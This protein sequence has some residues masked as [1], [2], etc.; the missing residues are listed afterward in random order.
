MLIMESAF[1]LPGRVA[2]AIGHARLKDEL[3]QRGLL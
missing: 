3:R 2:A 1:R